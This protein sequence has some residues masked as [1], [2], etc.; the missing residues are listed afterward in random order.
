MRTLLVVFALA[1]LTQTPTVSWGGDH[2]G[3]EVTAK[4]ATLEFDCAHAVID[5]VLRPDAKGAFRVKG[6]FTPEHG[7]PERDDAVSRGLKATFSGTIKDDAM[8]L[9]MVVDGQDP[10]GTTFQLKRGQ[11][12]ELR[13]CR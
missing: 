4:G 9:K 1:G 2:V 13:K 8:T 12:G 7:G 3:L 10:Q 5:E 11:P 6:T